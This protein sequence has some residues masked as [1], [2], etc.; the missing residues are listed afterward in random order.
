MMP[1]KIL[2]VDDDPLMH[3][4]YRPHIERAGFQLLSAKNGREALETAIRESPQVILM[5]IMMPD[6]DGLTALRELKKEE[7]TKSIPVIVITANL[8]AAAVTRKESELSGAA[9]FL[10][11]PLSPA[12]LL[13]EVRRL[14]PA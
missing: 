11:K 12:K 7:A 10:S 8:G 5:D 4:L 2:L 6:T 9:G 13:E 3:L 14:L 1:H